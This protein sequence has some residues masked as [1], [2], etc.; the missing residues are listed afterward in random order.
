[1]REGGAE[2]KGGGTA[3][4]G[5]RVPGAINIASGGYSGSAVGLGLGRRP[6]AMGMRTPQLVPRAVPGPGPASAT[7]CSGPAGRF[8]MPTPLFTP[9]PLSMLHAERRAGSSAAGQATGTPSRSGAGGVASV[10][11]SADVNAI[12]DVNANADVNASADVNL[13]ASASASADVD[14]A[15]SEATPGPPW[16]QPETSTSTIPSTSA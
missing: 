13:N 12:A 15:T 7:G 10:D 3:G 5:M 1:M 4:I 2:A 9:A 14:V 6:L 8:S 16:E 11:A